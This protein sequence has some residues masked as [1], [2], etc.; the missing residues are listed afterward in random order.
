MLQDPEDHK[1]LLALKDP[2]VPQVLQVHKDPE[3]HKDQREP[4]D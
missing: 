2:M 4:L 1:D 3:G